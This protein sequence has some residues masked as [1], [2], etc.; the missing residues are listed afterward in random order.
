MV[1]WPQSA[2]YFHLSNSLLPKIPVLVFTG[3]W[4]PGSLLL[5]CLCLTGWPLKTL[6]CLFH[7]SC[8]FSDPVPQ[9]VSSPLQQGLC[10]GPSPPEYVL[11]VQG[12]KLAQRS[13]I[14][15][16][17]E[18]TWD[19]YK[20]PGDVETMVNVRADPASVCQSPFSAKQATCPVLSDPTVFNV[21]SFHMWATSAKCFKTL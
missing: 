14:A 2:V 12:Y 1:I 11:R 18:N 8:L 13:Q 4:N 19:F 3:H 6:G 20:R 21:L 7:V 17:E 5:Q 9:L 10:L 16:N 15:D